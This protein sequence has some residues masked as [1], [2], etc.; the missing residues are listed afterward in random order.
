MSSTFN[1]QNFPSSATRASKTASP[2]SWG[3]QAFMVILGLAAVELV[4]LLTGTNEVAVIAA[5]CLAIPSF[6][7]MR[8]K[9]GAAVRR[10]SSIA[11]KYGD[12][13][14]SAF[15]QAG[16]RMI[17][18]CRRDK[19][20]MSVVVFDQSD[21]PELQVIFGPEVAL[22]MITQLANSLQAITPTRGLA[23][24][25]DP[26][27]FTVLLPGFGRDRALAAVKQALGDTFSIEIDA[28]GEDVVLVP[29]FLVHTVRPETSS[30]KEVYDGMRQ[31]IKRAQR[32]EQH[33]QQYL[34]RERESH[35][36]RPAPLTQSA[37]SYSRSARHE[38]TVPV[39]LSMR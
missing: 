4:L 32:Q 31:T 36:T 22:K 23:L 29:D 27:V 1:T 20:P 16:D 9:K 6:I 19:L 8:A 26:T 11:A 21:L 12:G 10:T 7:A 25:T 30:I 18:R 3:K 38:M 24:R 34:R 37:G 39:P 2:W 17:A 5:G 33:R 35:S 28:D 13:S 14:R 15:L